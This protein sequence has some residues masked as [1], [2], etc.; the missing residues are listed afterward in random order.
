M[1]WLLNGSRCREVTKA[2]SGPAQ[3]LQMGRLDNLK[4]AASARSGKSLAVILSVR[5]FFVHGGSLRLAARRDEWHGGSW[6]RV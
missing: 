3:R 1:R 4:P 6:Q 2:V 5:D